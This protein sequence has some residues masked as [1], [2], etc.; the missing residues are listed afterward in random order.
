MNM[1]RTALL[2]LALALA[3]SGCATHLPPNQFAQ[4][5]YRAL[6]WASDFDTARAHAQE[7]GQ[8]DGFGKVGAVSLTRRRVLEYRNE[9]LVHIAV[10]V[11]ALNQGQKAIMEGLHAVDVL[12]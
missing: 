9:V 11:D 3:A 7:Q 8:G 4:Q 6:P 2:A 5:K 1:L 10:D 12:S